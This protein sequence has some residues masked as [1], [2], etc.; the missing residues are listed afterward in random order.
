MTK[1]AVLVGSLRNGS[2]NKMLAKNLESLAPSGTE[3][4]YLDINLP[5]FNQ[6]LEANLPNEVKNLKNTIESADGVL[7]VT[8]EYN[9]GF[10][11][12]LKNAIDWASRPWGYNSFKGKPVCITG[13][14]EGP[15]GTA[16]A[17]A[18]LRNIMIYLDTKLMGQPELY[19]NFSHIFDENNN[20]ID[21][22][23]DHLISYIN[24]VVTHIESNK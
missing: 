12:V 7:I 20:I 23:K 6:E 11:G 24:A 17:Q 8:P 4:I 10:P 21:S 18:Q 9:R 19:A 15:T 2:I 1:I 16:Q 14:S 3:F 22:T 5:L 13:L